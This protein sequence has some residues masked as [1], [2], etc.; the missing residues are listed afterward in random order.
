MCHPAIAGRRGFR[1][2]ANDRWLG[3]VIYMVQLA[4]VIVM[5][6]MAG[7]AIVLMGVAVGLAIKR[8]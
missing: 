4:V 3:E 7:A 2:L 6:V 5:A 8:E 1:T